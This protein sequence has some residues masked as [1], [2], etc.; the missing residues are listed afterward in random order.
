[1]KILPTSSTH[2]TITIFESSTS[3]FIRLQYSK[4]EISFSIINSSKTNFNASE[5]N[6]TIAFPTVERR[7]PLYFPMTANLSNTICPTPPIICF[8]SAP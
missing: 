3:A 5:S 1:M 6:G 7:Y 2:S 8:G 4:T